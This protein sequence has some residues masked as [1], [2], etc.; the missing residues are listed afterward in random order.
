M[1]KCVNSV[2][3]TVVNGAYLIK[4]TNAK[5]DI[6]KLRQVTDSYP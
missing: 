3:V 5:Y 6:Y 2:N 4:T 1:L